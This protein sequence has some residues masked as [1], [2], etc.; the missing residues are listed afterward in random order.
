MKRII[1]F[2]KNSVRMC[3]MLDDRGK[4]KK[5]EKKEEKQLYTNVEMYRSLKSLKK[6]IFFLSH[7]Q[8]VK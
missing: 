5:K 3:V 2:T 1:Y 7:N 4:C 8:F 6:K